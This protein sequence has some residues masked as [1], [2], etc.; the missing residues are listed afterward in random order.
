MLAFVS[1]GVSVAMYVLLLFYY[2]MPGPTVVR[3]MMARR[4]RL[5]GPSRPRVAPHDAVRH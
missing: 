3:W 4:V 2:A 5:L 1:V